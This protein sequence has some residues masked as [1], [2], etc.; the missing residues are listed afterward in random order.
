MIK[1][2]I[3]LLTL[4]VFSAVLMVNLDRHKPSITGKLTVKKYR[5]E[6]VRLLFPALR[7]VVG[8]VLYMNT[9]YQIGA[10]AFDKSQKLEP[11][12]WKNI[13]FNLHTINQLDPYAF[14]PYYLMAAYLPWELRK[15]PEQILKINDY[16]RYGM[17]KCKDWRIPF[18][19]GFNYFYF[20]K[21]KELG[22]K[23]F[24]I[25]SQM[26]GAPSYLKLLSSKLYA[27]SGKIDVAIAVTSEELKN[28]KDESAKKILQKRLK[29]LNI[30]KKLTDV[31]LLYKKRFGKCPESLEELEKR[32]LLRYIPDEPYGGRFYIDKKTCTVWTTSDLK[33]SSVERKNN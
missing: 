16:L 30:M 24:R 14:D 13:V 5:Y 32:G 26:K 7:S 4:F 11:E 19:I 3:L 25:A 22:A 29:A 33:G 23:Y 6:V 18:F 9:C 20:L 12:D 27:K 28:T 15:S 2:I 17:K 1:K 8:D 21:N 31:V 10:G